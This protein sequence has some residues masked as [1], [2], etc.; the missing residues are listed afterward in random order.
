MIHINQ[1]EYYNMNNI[2]Q[3]NSANAVV[4]VTY[5]GGSAARSSPADGMN[6]Q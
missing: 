4:P 5:G 2:D 3:H 1:N 6:Q